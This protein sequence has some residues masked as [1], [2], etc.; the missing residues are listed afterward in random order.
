MWRENGL[1]SG[2]AL[3][4]DLA[5][6]EAERTVTFEFWYPLMRVPIVAQPR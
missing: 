6:A 2:Q 3:D 1:A 5:S 4:A